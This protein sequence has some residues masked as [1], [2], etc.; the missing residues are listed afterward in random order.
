[1]ASLDATSKRVSNRDKKGSALKKWGMTWSSPKRLTDRQG[2]QGAYVV[3]DREHNI[4]VFWHRDAWP[5]ALPGS[6][7]QMT[8]DVQSC[9]IYYFDCGT[10]EMMAS[11]DGGITFSDTVIVARL[12]RKHVNGD[13]DLDDGT[14]SASLIQA[15]PH[16]FTGVL[17]ATWNDVGT[18][19][20]LR[21]GIGDYDMVSSDDQE[22]T[23]SFAATYT[24]N[25]DVY[26][27]NV[28]V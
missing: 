23:V 14:R 21:Y 2:T 18:S 7:T 15:V 6:N 9:E 12:L 4:Y 22:F 5:P 27:V 13:L 1:M 19:S 3:T 11:Y 24:G 20:G 25:W 28:A 10:F 16:P 8:A 26:T 17:Y